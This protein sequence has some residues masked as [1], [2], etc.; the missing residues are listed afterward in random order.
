MHAHTH[1]HTSTW[2][3]FQW[4][5]TSTAWRPHLALECPQCSA[6][7][8]L[9]EFIF[10]FHWSILALMEPLV[11]FPIP[12]LKYNW[13]LHSLLFPIGWP[14]HSFWDTSISHAHLLHCTVSLMKT[15]PSYSLLHPCPLAQWLSHH[16]Y[17]VNISQIKFTQA[18]GSRVRIHTQDYPSPLSAFLTVLH[19]LPRKWREGFTA[20]PR[21]CVL[22]TAA[23]S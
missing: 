17:S 11:T 16:R 7:Y 4:L 23:Y 8:L 21:V 13:P 1:T 9:G 20:D 22:T 10:Q 18:G 12:F 5:S 19:C 3:V 6:V 15:G 14:K 2:Q